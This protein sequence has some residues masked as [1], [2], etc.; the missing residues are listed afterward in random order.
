MIYSITLLLVLLAPRSAFSF[1]LQHKESLSRNPSKTT[2]F[3]SDSIETDTKLVLTGN[4]IDLTES[5]EDYTAK[6]IGGLLEKLGGGGLVRECEVHLSVSKNPKVKN[7]HRVDC[8]TSL[9]G[10]T[11]HCKEER[12]DMYASID[13]AAKALASKLQKFRSRR[14]EGYHAGSSMGKDLMDA[15]DAMELSDTAEE[16]EN[17]ETDLV[18]AEKDFIDVNAPNLMK[19]NSFDLENAIP[20]NEAVFALDYVDHDF[21]V[22]KNEE[23]GKPSIVYK[24]NAGGVGLIEIP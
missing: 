23:T 3:M 2:V 22:F 8:T 15:L 18:Y 14:N 16:D 5:L 9:K 17:V 6:R 4:N 10:L 21:F 12:P 1:T 13:A 24:R 7:A 11:I 19:V 20:I